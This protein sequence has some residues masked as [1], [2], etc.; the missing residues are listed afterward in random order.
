M[1]P[2]VRVMLGIMQW[3][4][5]ANSTK[6][7]QGEIDK[8]SNLTANVQDGGNWKLC[9]EQKEKPPPLVLAVLL[10]SRYKAVGM[11]GEGTGSG[12]K[13]KRDSHVKKVQLR[14]RVTTGKGSW[15]LDWNNKGQ[16]A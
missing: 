2:A 11:E 13:P 3:H 5:Q 1:Y 15:L 8:A 4:R 9:S 14:T 12:S 7:Q 10:T 16:L 6:S